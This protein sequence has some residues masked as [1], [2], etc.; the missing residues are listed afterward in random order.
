MVGRMAL[1]A[2]ANEELMSGKRHCHGRLQAG[3]RLDPELGLGILG[4]ARQ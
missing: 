2:S 4:T 3:T 1:R